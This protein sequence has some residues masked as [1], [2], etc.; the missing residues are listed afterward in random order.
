MMLMEEIAE[1]KHLRE[2]LKLQEQSFRDQLA[3]FRKEWKI[4]EDA[5]RTALLLQSEEYA[6]RLEGLNHESARI[7]AA[8]DKAV[9][10]ELY[11][12]DQRAQALRFADLE[13]RQS[14]NKEALLSDISLRAGQAMAWAKIAALIAVVIPVGSFLIYLINCTRGG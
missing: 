7:K 10:A 1:I 3:A 4:Q 9:S 2:L 11:H 14:E 5:N 13:R 12:A 6:R 8:T